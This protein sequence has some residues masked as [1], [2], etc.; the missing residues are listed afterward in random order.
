MTR[1]PFLI[2]GLSVS[3]TLFLPSQISR[4]PLK[5][6]PL[7]IWLSAKMIK[8][9]VIQTLQVSGPTVSWNRKSTRFECHH[10]PTSQAGEVLESHDGTA[11]YLRSFSE[12][13]KYTFPFGDCQSSKASKNQLPRKPLCLSLIVTGG[14]GPEGPCSPACPCPAPPGPPPHCP[15]PKTT[16]AQ[17]RAI[18]PCLGSLPGCCLG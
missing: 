3:Y 12:A 9:R 10:F 5:K 16:S 15:W 6:I 14:P 7:G 4:P 1:R 2:L 11:L 17:P 18:S 13:T 8:A